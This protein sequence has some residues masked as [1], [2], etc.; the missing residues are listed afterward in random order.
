VDCADDFTVGYFCSPQV[1]LI[2]GDFKTKDI[3]IM[4]DRDT[5]AFRGFCYVEFETPDDLAAALLLD[6]VVSDLLSSF[7]IFVP[8]ITT[9]WLRWLARCHQSFFSYW[10]PHNL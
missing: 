6:G 7:V 1:D 5:G 2:F 10:Q 8:Y 4:T 3:R 9:G